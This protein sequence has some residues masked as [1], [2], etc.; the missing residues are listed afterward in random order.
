[1]FKGFVSS[2]YS[3]KI[4]IWSDLVPLRGVVSRPG[5]I[6][7]EFGSFFLPLQIL[8]IKRKSVRKG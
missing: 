6:G 1:M 4:F 7:G 8:V 2:G 3:T 5:E